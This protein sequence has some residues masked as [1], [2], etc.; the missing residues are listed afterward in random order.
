MEYAV[1]VTFQNQNYLAFKRELRSY[2]QSD[3]TATLMT[4]FK[5]RLNKTIEKQQKK[6][7]FYGELQNWSL[8]LG[9]L[10]YIFWHGTRMWA[11][12]A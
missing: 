3:E 4:S 5:S 12:N 2:Q 8:L 6:M 1:N 11:L 7:K 9:G 10:A